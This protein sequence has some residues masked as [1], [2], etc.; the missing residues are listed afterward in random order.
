MFLTL[1]LVLIYFKMH[2]PVKEILPSTLKII[3]KLYN[4]AQHLPVT[5]NQ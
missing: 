5:T 3:Y 2:L 1:L 4:T